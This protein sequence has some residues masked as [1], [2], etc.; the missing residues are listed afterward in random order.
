M[1]PRIDLR[2]RAPQALTRASLRGVL[3]RAVL[4][5]AAAAEQVRPVCEDV[6]H[7]GAAAVREYTRRFDRVELDATR[8]P[9]QA[10]DDALGAPGPRL[11]EVDMTAIGAFA[12]RFAGPPAGAAGGVR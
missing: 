9:E 1:L 2:G 8:V 12:E 6:R 5:V 7:R 3:P 11:V 10:L 4:D